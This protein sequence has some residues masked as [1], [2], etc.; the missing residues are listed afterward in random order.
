MIFSPEYPRTLNNRPCEIPH[1]TLPRWIKSIVDKM[2]ELVKG[3]GLRKKLA[4]GGFR[5]ESLGGLF[6]SKVRRRYNSTLEK[7]KEGQSSG[8][9][10]I[11]NRYL[12]IPSR[13][14]YR[15]IVPDAHD[16]MYIYRAY[17]SV[18]RF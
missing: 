3:Q 15:S 17:E 2:L 11:S 7:D 10:D 1:Q 16:L 5:G 9:S 4:E 6:A 14:L 12:T 8:S 13:F 18:Q